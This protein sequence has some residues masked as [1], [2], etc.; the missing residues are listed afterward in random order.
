VRSLLGAPL[1]SAGEP[2]GVLY[3]GSRADAHFSDEDA[4]VMGL[5]AERASIAID[6]ARSYERERGLVE[7]LQRS[8][9]PERLPQVERLLMAARYRPSGDAAQVGGDWYDA[10]MLPDGRVGLAIG[11]VVGHGVRAATIMGEL[12]NALRAYAMEGH[13]AGQAVQRLNALV[14]ATHEEAMVATLAFVLLDPGTGAGSLVSAGH[15]P[16]L[17]LM[18]DGQSRYLERAPAPPLGVSRAHIY[19]EHELQLEPGCTLVFYTDGLVE[20]RGE[21]LDVGLKDLRDAVSEGP[22]DLEELCSHVLASLQEGSPWTDDV[23]VL[24]V[25]LLPSPVGGVTLRLPAEPASVTVARRALERLLDGAGASADDS[26]ALR[27]AISEACANAVEHAYGPGDHEFDV[28]AHVDN[29]EVELVVRDNGRWR[30]PR[31]H[32]RGLGLKLVEQLNDT[33]QIDRAGNGTSLRVTKR[34]AGAKPPSGE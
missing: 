29:G 12:R 34:L 18:P 13:S 15:L 20:R 23:A 19:A 9:L 31:G 14:E 1:A 16:P 8:L 30:M 6:H 3:V 10:I 2:L 27:L 32:G 21:S 26:F 4:V 11:D 25:R 7:T 24:V 17:M 33:L 28:E 22:D 5:G